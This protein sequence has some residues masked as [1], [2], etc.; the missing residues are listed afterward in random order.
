MIRGAENITK[1][2]MGKEIR[3]PELCRALE[4]M[5]N[6]ILQSLFP[7]PETKLD[8]KAMAA[9]RASY[10]RAKGILELDNALAEYYK[11]GEEK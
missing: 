11:N 2:F 1:Y 8:D 4:I 6:T 10:D 9:I 5:A 3:N 7:E